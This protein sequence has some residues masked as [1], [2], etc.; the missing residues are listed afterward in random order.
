MSTATIQKPQMFNFFFNRKPVYTDFSFL[1][2]DLHSHLIPGIDDGAQTIEE[3]IQLI[4][5]L[6]AL[7]YKKIITTPHVMV[8]M[9]PNTR[10]DILEGLKKL[11]K[12]VAKEKIDIEIEAA[13]EYMLDDGFDKLVEEKEVLTLG[14]RYLLFETSMISSYPGLE[15]AIFKM[16][17]KGY[18]PIMAHPERYVYMKEDFKKYIRLKDMGCLFQLNLLS[19]I[20]YYGAPSRKIAVKLLQEGMVDFMATDLHHEKHLENLAALL[21]NRRA[22]HLLGDHE[23]SNHLL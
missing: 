7:G 13:A 16:R 22:N 1:G 18:I 8:D 10:N 12:A 9:Y 14:D 17:T 19:L 4:K 20:G 2:T 5:G 3:S 15:D 11:R 21:K 6:K 23:F